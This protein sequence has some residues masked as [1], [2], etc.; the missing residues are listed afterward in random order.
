[1]HKNLKIFMVLGCG[2]GGVG[3]IPWRVPGVGGHHIRRY[4]ALVFLGV[5]VGFWAGWR[6]GGWVGDLFGGGKP[7]KRNQES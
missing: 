2:V 4:P 6:L 7:N 5:G 1:M 3:G